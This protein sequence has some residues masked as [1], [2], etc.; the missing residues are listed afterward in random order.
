MKLNGR[1]EES[2]P[3]P[4]AATNPFLAPPEEDDDD[5]SGGALLAGT[6][7]GVAGSTAID[8]CCCNAF[9]MVAR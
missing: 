7:C 2:A 1:L 9:Q 3:R 5:G 4:A 8:L 6:R